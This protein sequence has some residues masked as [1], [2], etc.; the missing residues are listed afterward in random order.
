MLPDYSGINITA[1]TLG[2]DSKNS[3]HDMPEDQL[4]NLAQCL[5]EDVPAGGAV[6]INVPHYNSE[7]V[8]KV[9]DDILVANYTY[10]EH[11]LVVL[12]QPAA[13]APGESSKQP[14]H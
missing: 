11:D 4:H 12:V 14:L 2:C 8:G 3:R 5:T 6:V 13:K 1:K 7:K 10:D 9:L